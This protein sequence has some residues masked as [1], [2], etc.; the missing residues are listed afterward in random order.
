MPKLKVTVGERDQ[1]RDRTR[2][3]IEAAEE[4]VSLE[5]AQPVLNFESYA[6]LSRLLSQ[7]NL[8]LLEAIAEHEPDSIRHA[9]EIVDRDY[10][11]VHRNLTELEDVGVIEFEGGGSGRSKKPI[12]AYD[13]LEIDLP[14]T[15]SAN[16]TDVAL[17]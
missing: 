7:K 6:E 1:L 16:D 14:F 13:G 12:L 8:E 15:D 3:R 11:Q 17:S 4:D 5:D 9:A 10:K 2:R